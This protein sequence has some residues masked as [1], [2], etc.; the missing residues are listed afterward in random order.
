MSRISAGCGAFLAFAVSISLVLAAPASANQWYVQIGPHGHR[1][2]LPP[3][4]SA[5]VPAEGVVK[6]RIRLNGRRG[7]LLTTCT[8]I[9]TEVLSNPNAEEAL[10]STSG[11]GF[12]QCTGGVTVSSVLLPW[13]GTVG[14]NCQPCRIMLPVAL[15]VNVQG[16]DYG[17]FAGPLHGRIG[18]FDPPLRDDMDHLFR[19]QGGHGGQLVGESGTTTISGYENF[20]SKAQENMACAEPNTGLVQ[21]E[22]SAAEARRHDDDDGD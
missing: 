9:A 17:V 22:E 19:W 5:E 16:V 8:V 3:G 14:G 1:L 13:S 11:M 20:G 15:E 21:E 7:V 6:L 2:K 10:I 12:Y 4:G 18:D